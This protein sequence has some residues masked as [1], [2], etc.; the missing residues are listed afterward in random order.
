MLQSGVDDVESSR[1]T[2]TRRSR[3][4]RCRARYPRRQNNQ[5][6]LD[7]GPSPLRLP[8]ASLHRLSRRSSF[9]TCTR[10]RRRIYHRPRARGSPDKRPSKQHHPWF[11]PNSHRT[12][13]APL[14]ISSDSYE[15]LSSPPPH[16]PTHHSDHNPH[17]SDHSH[18]PDRTHPDRARPMKHPSPI[19]SLSLPSPLS[20]T[21]PSTQ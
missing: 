8:C 4:E 19:H 14:S 1:S 2:R 12:P 20:P 6:G 15:N 17:H 5:H 10:R 13:R 9:L 7:L 21:T 16:A 18:H 11:L 3:R